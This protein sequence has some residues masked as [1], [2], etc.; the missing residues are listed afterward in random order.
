[1]KKGSATLNKTNFARPR[2]E[3]ARIGIKLYHIDGTNTE[4]RQTELTFDY[5]A[6]GADS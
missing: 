6:T 1:V 3:T 4:S 5:F 2:T